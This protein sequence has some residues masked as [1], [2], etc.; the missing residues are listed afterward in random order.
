MSN[1]L[2]GDLSNFLLTPRSLWSSAGLVVV[3]SQDALI[4]R[5]CSL[6]YLGRDCYFIYLFY[7]WLCRVFLHTQKVPWDSMAFHSFP[8]GNFQKLPWD[9]VNFLFKEVSCSMGFILK[10]HE[11]PCPSVR[12]HGLLWV[13]LCFLLR[14][15]HQISGCS[16]MFYGVFMR[17]VDLLP[18]L[19]PLS[20]RI[21]KCS[22]NVPLI[23]QC[24]IVSEGISWTILKFYLFF[25]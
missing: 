14:R 3:V 11:V 20:H 4:L 18:S 7:W 6:P 1:L 17:F 8:I 19:S 13:I 10:F 16:M 12:F 5:S 22:I 9:S 21:P 23:P 2:E 25:S 24:S 15:F